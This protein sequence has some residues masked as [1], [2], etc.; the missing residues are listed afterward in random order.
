MAVV[1]V[2]ALLSYQIKAEDLHLPHP[3]RP[4][5]P[6]ITLTH[7]GSRRELSGNAASGV[8][9]AP[10]SLPYALGS[11]GISDGEAGNLISLL[12]GEN[13]TGTASDLRC[14]TFLPDWSLRSLCL[15]L[16]CAHRVRRTDP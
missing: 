16:F 15:P 7:G 6:I 12:E 8:G 5:H 3:P 10:V 13:G 11:S 14:V 4:F 2:H 9:D 1:V